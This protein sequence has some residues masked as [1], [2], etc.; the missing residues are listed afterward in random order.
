MLALAQAALAAS[1]ADHLETQR[2][3]SKLQEATKGL[4]I[5][6]FSK[7]GRNKSVPADGGLV[8]S[9]GDQTTAEDSGDPQGTM[10]Q[11][12]LHELHRLT[13][14]QILTLPPCSRHI[15]DYQHCAFDTSVPATLLTL[16]WAGLGG[17]KRDAS[18]ALIKISVRLC[19]VSQRTQDHIIH[20][21]SCSTGYPEVVV[22]SRTLTRNR[23]CG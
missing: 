18:H 9:G 17:G 5:M 8:A 7:H 13:T 22:D 16:V 12:Q 14:V 11:P 10:H 15:C 4:S 2:R 21:L 3:I 23:T 19:Q 20:I 1:Q 6:D